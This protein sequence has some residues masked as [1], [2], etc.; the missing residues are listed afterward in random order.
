MRKI[1]VL[2]VDDSTVIRRLVSDSLNSDNDLEVAGVAANGKI[3]LAK[4]P[5]LNPDVITLDVEMPEM[6]GIETVVEVRKLYPDLP[7]VMFSTLTERGAEATFDALAKGANDYVTKPAN[8]GSVSVAMQRVREELA[9]KVKALCGWFHQAQRPAAVPRATITHAGSSSGLPSRAGATSEVPRIDIVAIGT[10]TGGPNALQAVVPHLRG[11][12]PVPVVIVQH[13]PPVF[14]KHLADR[15]NQLSSLSVV[16]ASHRDTLHA[17]GVW[18]APGDFHMELAQVGTAVKVQ[19]NQGTPE[20]SCRPA[21]DVLF[22][23]VAGIY[24]KNVLAVILTGMGQDGVRGCEQIHSLGGRVL[25]Q[26]QATSVVWGMPGAVTQ[27]G[28]AHQ[29]LPLRHIAERI[30]S[31]VM[32][33]RAGRS[34]QPVGGLK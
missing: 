9:P 14:T 19:L 18:L 10:S 34:L 12:F 25:V 16:E 15:L 17:G 32:Q 4:I 28:L 3:A 5:Q 11:D 8:V 7:I 30:N 2:V 26:D 13:M 27:A 6:N 24:G 22:R 29:T 20:N 23:S 33:S 31:T 1:R 21:V